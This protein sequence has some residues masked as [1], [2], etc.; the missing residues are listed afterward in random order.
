MPG[1]SI[2]SEDDMVSSRKK[3]IDKDINKSIG[4]D[5]GKETGESRRVASYK[6]KPEKPIRVLRIKY[7]SRIK[8]PFMENG[9]VEQK[10][11]FA[12]D[13]SLEDLLKA[14]YYNAGI[15]GNI[16]PPGC[17][18]V[19]KDDKMGSN[20]KFI[21]VNIGTNEFYTLKRQLE[22]H[23]TICAFNKGEFSVLDGKRSSLSET[24][25][26]P[27]IWKG[28]D[29]HRREISD[30]NV[31]LMRAKLREEL[32]DE[33][34][35]YHSYTDDQID[36]MTENELIALKKLASRKMAIDNKKRKKIKKLLR[37]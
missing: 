37:Y 21:F 34:C 12:V 30:T 9:K 36:H 23:T 24:Y 16:V 15:Q 14:L 13:R 18:F 33:L 32:K 17:I 1:L 22:N 2:V 28:T 10:D 4:K 29:T 11:A 27:R 19:E 3:D 35:S 25:N 8:I 20:D 31:L 6:K 26:M 5:I 7:Y